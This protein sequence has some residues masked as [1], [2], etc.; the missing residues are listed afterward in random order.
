MGVQRRE[1]S[2]SVEGRR[3]EEAG[4]E[5]ALSWPLPDE[6]VLHVQYNLHSGQLVQQLRGRKW[7]V[8]YSVIHLKC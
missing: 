7:E 1:A 3:K 4:K 2:P 6:K 5:V 8:A